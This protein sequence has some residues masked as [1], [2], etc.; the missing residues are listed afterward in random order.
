MNTKVILDTNALLMPFQFGINLDVELERLLGDC[1]VLVPSSVFEELALLEQKKL[2]K[3]ARS[4]AS[5]FKMLEVEGK[6][7][8]AIISAAKSQKAVVVTNDRELIERLKAIGIK[9]AFLRSRSHLVLS[10]S[11][12]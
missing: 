1:E 6:G 2:A 5:K 12:L 4:L 8:E 7:D 10:A 3:A 9:V 11:F